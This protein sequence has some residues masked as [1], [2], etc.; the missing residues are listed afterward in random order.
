MGSLPYFSDEEED[1]AD[2][3]SQ[4]DDSKAGDSADNDG[5][6]DGLM[7]EQLERRSGRFM[8]LLLHVLVCCVMLLLHVVR[9]CK[10][11]CHS[12]PTTSI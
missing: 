10:P 7:D 4:D 2:S 9:C 12:L 1:S 6:V 3:S 5:D 8:L 11:K